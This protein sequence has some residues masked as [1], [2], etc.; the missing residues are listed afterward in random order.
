MRVGNLV[1]SRNNEFGLYA[2]HI[3]VDKSIDLMG[4]MWWRLIGT[5]SIGNE[6]D[7]WL[8]NIERHYEVVK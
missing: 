4:Q 5:S 2:R 1:Q 7:F 3:I 6:V 8:L